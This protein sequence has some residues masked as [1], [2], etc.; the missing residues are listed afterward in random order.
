MCACASGPHREAFLR[1]R[2]QTEQ[3][4]ELP[5]PPRP[6]G[7]DRP[8]IDSEAGAGSGPKLPIPPSPTAGRGHTWRRWAGPGRPPR[9][10]S[11]A[12]PRSRRGRVRADP[13]RPGVTAEGA[14]A[15][16]REAAIPGAWEA[17]ET[18]LVGPARSRARA[19]VGQAAEGWSSTNS[20]RPLPLLTEV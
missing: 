8:Y 14:L 3:A 5:P 18:Q 6:H 15:P 2:S 12:E 20:A 4:L 19:R 11:R 1:D 16:L 17:S 9:A 13:S 10:Q 7:R